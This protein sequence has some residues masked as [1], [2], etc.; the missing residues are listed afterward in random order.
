MKDHPNPCHYQYI[1]VKFDCGNLSWR[2]K[3]NDSEIEGYDRHDEAPDAMMDWS[4]EDI[5]YHVK[6]FLC[7]E[8]DDPVEIELEVI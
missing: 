3:L 5:I 6:N 8:D 4:D 1:R 2:Y 7:V